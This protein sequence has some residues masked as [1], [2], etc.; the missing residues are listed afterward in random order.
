MTEV[1]S[2]S[3]IRREVERMLAIGPRNLVHF[4]RLPLLV[5]CSTVTCHTLQ[6]MDHLAS[7]RM[8]LMLEVDIFGKIDT[9]ERND[10]LIFWAIRVP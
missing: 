8:G 2:P 4:T 7:R 6:S 5:E 1:F 10:V 9:L 3:T